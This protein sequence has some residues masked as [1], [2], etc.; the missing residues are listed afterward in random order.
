MLSRIREL[1]QERRNVVLASIFGVVALV[2]VIAWAA[3]PSGPP[4]DADPQIAK[5]DRA[6]AKGDLETL[7]KATKSDTD[8]RVAGAALTHLARLDR[9]NA[10]E[11]ITRGL[12]DSRWQVRQQAVRAVPRVYTRGSTDASVIDMLNKLGKTDASSE[13]RGAVAASTIQLGWL[14][15][16]KAWTL[17][18]GLV[19]QLDDPE[20]EVRL[21]AKTSLEKVLY[22][23]VDPKDYDVEAPAPNAKRQRYMAWI[24]QSLPNMK[25]LVIDFYDKQAAKS[26]T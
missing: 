13:V 10:R 16:E 25:S 23:T 4:P 18:Q 14:D 17:V 1:F 9:G 8:G 7:R 22:L 24:R 26:G 5:L 15:G 12:S 19:E 6:A 11:Y 20:R 2:T 3:L 21:T